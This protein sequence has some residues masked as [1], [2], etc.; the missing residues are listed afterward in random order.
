MVDNQPEVELRSASMSTPD[1]TNELQYLRTQLRDNIDGFR[2]Q[3]KKS[4]RRTILLRI[5]L[6]SLGALTTLL[7]GLKSNPLFALYDNEFSA[8][9]LLFSATIPILS[10]WD[11]MFDYQWLWVRFTAAHT[12][13]Y[14]ILTELNYAA[15]KGALSTERLDAF[16]NQF[17]RTI[18]E[19]SSAWLE[20]QSKLLEGASSAK[21]SQA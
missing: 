1:S 6:A 12:G 5:A 11:A 14:G 8:L 13:L 16:N 19:T 3:A 2:A 9:A 17:Q 18:Q 4:K 15:A 7:L 10:T 20:K 21:M